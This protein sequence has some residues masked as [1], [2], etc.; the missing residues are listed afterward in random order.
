M[1][2]PTTERETGPPEM[3]GS[4]A[5]GESLSDTS[6]RV[7]LLQFSLGQRAFS[8]FSPARLG[9]QIYAEHDVDASPS[10]AMR[11]LRD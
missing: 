8:P 6:S 4:L 5:S 3:G 2:D 1:V 10:H 11:T 9:H 7:P